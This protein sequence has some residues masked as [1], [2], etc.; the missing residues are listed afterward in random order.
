M[1]SQLCVFFFF[2]EDLWLSGE[3]KRRAILHHCAWGRHEV[4]RRA[5]LLPVDVL[6]AFCG[7]DTLAARISLSSSNWRSS[8]NVVVSVIS[9]QQVWRGRASVDQ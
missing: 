6:L 9:R 5:A 7:H 1:D 8:R 4:P 3:V 2:N